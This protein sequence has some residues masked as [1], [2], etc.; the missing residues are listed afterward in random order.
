MQTSGSCDFSKYFLLKKW[1]LVKGH[2][3]KALIYILKFTK[4]LSSDNLETH[5]YKKCKYTRFRETIE[6]LS[7]N[8]CWK[9]MKLWMQHEILFCTENFTLEEIF[10]KF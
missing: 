9:K 5:L 6:N 7:Q 10:E 4:I 2:T 8:E 1:T 3:L